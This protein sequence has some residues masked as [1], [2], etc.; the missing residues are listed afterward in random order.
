[1]RCNRSEAHC[2]AWSAL[3]SPQQFTIRRVALR[4][5]HALRFCW[6][7]CPAGHAATTFDACP[8]PSRTASGRHL[9]FTVNLLLR[10]IEILRAA[11]PELHGN[12]WPGTGS[13]QFDSEDTA[14]QWHQEVRLPRS[15][16]QTTILSLFQQQPKN[17][18]TR[19]MASHIIRPLRRGMEQSTSSSITPKVA[20]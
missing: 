7:N 1:M 4:F 10:H 6:Q 18:L 19:L 14:C 15:C 20:G 2:T 9:F 5:E 13:I 17:T 16:L 11:V 12:P 3:G 8:L